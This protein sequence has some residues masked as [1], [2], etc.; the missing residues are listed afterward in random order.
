LAL[1]LQCF[2]IAL[3]F[4]L[5]SAIPARRTA[6]GQNPKSCLNWLFIQ[7][8]VIPVIRYIFKSIEDVC[9]NLLIMWKKQCC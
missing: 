4:N 6:G 3:F 9:I 2:E 1:N 8:L 7:A 5:K